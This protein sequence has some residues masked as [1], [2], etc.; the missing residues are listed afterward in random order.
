MQSPFTSPGTSVRTRRAN[1]KLA[2]VCF[3]GSFI[4]GVLCFVSIV[5]FWQ[6]V[7]DGPYY[8]PPRP[9][10]ITLIE[11]M[12]PVSAAAAVVLGVVFWQAAR[13]LPSTH[14]WKELSMLVVLAMLAATVP[15]GLSLFGLAI[16]VI[17]MFSP[18]EVLPV[19]SG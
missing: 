3:C 15:L 10:F 18:P 1:P 7:L 14:P 8:L 19:I 6:A 13:Y 11:W 4:S 2:G 5:V 16:T 17:G 9:W 12:V